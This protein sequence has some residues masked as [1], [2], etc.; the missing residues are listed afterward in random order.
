VR[1]FMKGLIFDERWW[2]VG[3]R[4]RFVEVEVEYKSLWAMT[5]I[6]HGIWADATLSAYHGTLLFP[7]SYRWASSAI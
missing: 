5:G 1:R 6:H 7:Y 4:P 2:K 3:F